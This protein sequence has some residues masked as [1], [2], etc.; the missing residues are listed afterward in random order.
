[1]FS[2]TSYR[3]LFQSFFPQNISL[4]PKIETEAHANLKKKIT[5][6]NTALKHIKH[7]YAVMVKSTPLWNVRVFPV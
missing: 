5:S 1:M 7:C 2:S 6:C 3:V 4:L